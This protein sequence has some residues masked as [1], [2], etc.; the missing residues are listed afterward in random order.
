[1]IIQIKECFFT[2]LIV[3]S[4]LIY[5]SSLRGDNNLENQ[6][7]QFSHER[8]KIWSQIDSLERAEVVYGISHVIE[9]QKKGDGYKVRRV[10]ITFL[11]FSIDSIW[12]SSV[13]RRDNDR[14]SIIANT[15]LLNDEIQNYIEKNDSL[16]SFEMSNESEIEIGCTS[17]FS[18]YKNG[19][20]EKESL[21]YYG[22]EGMWG[23]KPHV[24][25]MLLMVN[26]Q[27][28]CTE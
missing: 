14:C 4:S 19:D 3:L 13:I 10:R 1:M 25:S 7:I 15:V 28:S 27:I 23:F 8:H 20:V 21:L 18:Y 9:S 17:V 22:I 24:I 6:D 11:I 2:L 26:N 5:C 12:Y 16:I